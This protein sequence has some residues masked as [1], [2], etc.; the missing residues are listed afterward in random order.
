MLITEPFF[1]AV[2]IPAVLLVGISKGGFGGGVG[3][4]GVPMIALAIPLVQAAAILL[5]IL[6]VMDLFAIRAYRG[7]YSE[8]NLRILLPAAIAGIGAG[9]FAFGALDEG[10]IRALVGCVALAFAAQYWVGLLKRRGQEAD[11]RVPGM[12]SGIFWGTAAGFTST[13]A[14]AGGPP[15]S[16]YLLP[17]RMP[18]TVFV[19]TTVLLFT[20]LNYLKLGPYA[21]L[22]QLHFDNLATSLAL[23]PLAPLGIALGRWLH[24]RI[25]EALF[26]RISYGLLVIVGSKLVWDAWSGRL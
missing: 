15:I 25:N 16:V 3:L 6:C 23:A 18:R 22:G 20:A 14:H 26:Y 11:P 17:Q 21:L 4:L 9:S 13:V 1:Y 7:Q 19:G 2:A 5:P 8:R 12:A 10:L 24:H